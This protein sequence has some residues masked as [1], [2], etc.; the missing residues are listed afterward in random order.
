MELSRLEK[1][2]IIAPQIY[3][4][5]EPET[6]LEPGRDVAPQRAEIPMTWIL[7][8]GHFRLDIDLPADSVLDL[9]FASR[10]RSLHVNGETIWENDTP[11]AVSLTGAHAEMTPGGLRLTCTSG[12]SLHILARCV[13]EA[14][15]NW[16]WSQ[17]ARSSAE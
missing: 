2:I 17:T 4:A 10:V 1:H 7:D 8:G 12:G 16:R 5:L 3:V 6:P 13:L 9:V 14:E 15:R 11:H